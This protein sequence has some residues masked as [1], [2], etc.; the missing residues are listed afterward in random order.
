MSAPQPRALWYTGPGRA[1]LRDEPRRDPSPAQV[2]VAAR[3]SGISR[4]SERLVFEGRVPVS[5]HARMRAPFQAGAFPFPVK[6]G[7]ASVG[8]VLAGPGLLLGR[9]VFRRGMDL[10]FERHDGR[11]AT[12][13]E[14]VAGLVRGA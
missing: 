5:E 13:E 11:A 3:Y 12:I 1:E 7:Y 4:G 14:F 10:Y 9:D 8:R 6:Y 2:L